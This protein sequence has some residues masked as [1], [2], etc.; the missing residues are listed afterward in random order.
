MLL[1][2][3]IEL[4]YEL[5]FFVDKLLQLIIKSLKIEQAAK[6]EILKRN[7]HALAP[8]HLLGHKD[9][10][11]LNLNPKSLVPH[12]NAPL[13]PHYGARAGPWSS[14]LPTNPYNYP[15]PSGPWHQF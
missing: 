11:S 9:F 2:R 8:P 5:V 1:P 6:F 4:V 13:F 15:K 3:F 12:F 14:H 7:H 10:S